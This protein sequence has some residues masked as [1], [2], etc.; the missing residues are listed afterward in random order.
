MENTVR[1]ATRDSCG[2]LQFGHGSEPW[3]TIGTDLHT[4]GRA[5]LQFGHGSEPWRTLRGQLPKARIVLLQFGHGSEPWRT[6]HTEGSRVIDEP[7]SI[8]PRQ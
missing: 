2:R 5:M 6:R 8:R 7:A 3:R 1:T 4:E